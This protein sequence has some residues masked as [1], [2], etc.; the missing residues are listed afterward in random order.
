MAGLEVNNDIEGIVERAAEKAAEKVYA[1]LKENAFSEL[2]TKAELRELATK[3]DIGRIR[4][5]I[6]TLSSKV[7]D[8]HGFTQH[9]ARDVEELKVRLD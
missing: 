4:G 1:K 5:D 3:D 2:A 9:I 7:D 6:A 8:L